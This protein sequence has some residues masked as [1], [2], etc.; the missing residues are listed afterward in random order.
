M[1]LVNLILYKLIFEHLPATDGSFPCSKLIRVIRSAVARKLFDSCGKDVNIEKGADFGRGREISIGDHSGIGINC[2]VRGPL[3]IGDNV[4]MGPE[5][6]ILTSIHKFDDVAVPMNHQSNS[7]KKPV[8]IG[9]DVWIGTRAIIMPGVTI[10]NGVVIGAGA[11]VTKDVP[12]Y[13]IVGGVPA[14]IIKYRK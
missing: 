3:S 2:K 5:V 10:G 7:E 11:V 14:K 4:M 13:A 8:T 12:D 1:K 6:I 9:N